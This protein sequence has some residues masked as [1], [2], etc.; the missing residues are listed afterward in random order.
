MPRVSVTGFLRGL[1]ERI[2]AA[3]AARPS[4]ASSDTLY[5]E[6]GRPRSMLA[7]ML[8]VRD[9]SSARI[10]TIAARVARKPASATLHEIQALGGSALSGSTT[11][12][13]FFGATMPTAGGLAARALHAPATLSLAERRS[14]AQSALAH[15]LDG[16]G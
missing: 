11:R 7:T 13:A 1:R 8:A 3:F 4:G 10:G 2:D 12:S 14:V 5:D 6:S 16:E 15:V 9:D